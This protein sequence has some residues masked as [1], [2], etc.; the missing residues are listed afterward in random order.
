MSIYHRK[1]GRPL[2][3]HSLLYSI[4]SRRGAED[5]N[6]G[7]K[8]KISQSLRFFEM[9]CVWLWGFKTPS[10]RSRAGFMSADTPPQADRDHVPGEGIPASVGTPDLSVS[11]IET[12]G[13]FE[14]RLPALTAALMGA[15][16]LCRQRKGAE[17]FLIS[18]CR[19]GVRHDRYVVLGVEVKGEYRS[20]HSSWPD[21]VCRATYC[22]PGPAAHITCGG[23]HGRRFCALPH[24]CC[25]AGDQAVQT[26]CAHANE[27][28]RQRAS[29]C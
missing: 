23:G 24:P 15:P 8:N 27:G 29:A 2:S 7:Y 20:G 25:P 3:M 14:S 4:F 1:I 18:G 17:F 11:K 21:G 19:I 9:T 16:S 12:P 22:D 5:K 10:F 6:K 13:A 26:R 28:Q